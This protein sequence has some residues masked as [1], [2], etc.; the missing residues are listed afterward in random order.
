VS[1]FGSSNGL[2]PG[3]KRN[4]QMA[5]FHDARSYNDYALAA[6]SSWDKEFSR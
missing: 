3:H 1:G 2:E 5:E 6:L 4:G